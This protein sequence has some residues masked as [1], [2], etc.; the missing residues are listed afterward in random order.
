MYGEN[1][2]SL[3]VEYENVTHFD[4]AG[5]KGDQWKHA[6]ITLTNTVYTMDQKVLIICIMTRTMYIYF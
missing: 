6:A 5:N 1:V 4:E 3:D 2:G